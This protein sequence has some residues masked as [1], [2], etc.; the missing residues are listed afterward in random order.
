VIRRAV[1][2]DISSAYPYSIAMQARR[3]K[4][5]GRLACF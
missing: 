1:R 2:F 5:C 4:G 3:S